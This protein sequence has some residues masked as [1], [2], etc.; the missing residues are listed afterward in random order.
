MIF[1]ANNA[2]TYFT[3]D[4]MISCLPEYYYGKFFVVAFSV[5]FLLETKKC[6]YSLFRPFLCFT[7][8]K[9]AQ[10]FN[11]WPAHIFCQYV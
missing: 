11:F 10:K 3:S 8:N 7:T 1:V 4:E 2:V 5:S 9:F 6:M